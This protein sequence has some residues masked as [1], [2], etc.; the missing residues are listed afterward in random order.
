MGEQPDQHHSAAQV[1]VEAGDDVG[2]DPTA[3]WAVEHLMEVLTRRGIAVVRQP[4][5]RGVP[6]EPLR[7]SLALGGSGAP[8]APESFTVSRPADR[9]RTIA[10]TGA[11]GRGL[12]YAVLDLADTA[13]LAAD[14]LDA[15]TRTTP[16]SGVP[17][18]P[19]RS[20][21]RIF[22]SDVEDTPWFH[23]RSFWT[24]YLTE[25]ATHR[26]NRLQLAFGM[27]YN[28]SY[29]LNV[30]DNY[31]CFAY[32]FLVD[33]PGYDVRA[34]GVSDEERARNLATLQWVSAEAK[35]RGLH[36]QLGL[37]NHAYEMPE[38]PN[39]RYPITGVTPENHAE[40]ASAG[41]EA[42]LRACP[43]IDGLTLRV[44][45]EGGV[46]EPGHDF[47]RTVMGAVSRVG[48]PL[49]IDMHAKGVDA[50]L[51][52]VARGSG[53]SVVVSAKYWAEHL[54]LPYHQV[55][56]RS[57]EEA[58]KEPGTGLKS[59][60]RHQRR[61][62]RYGYGDFLRE[63]RDHGLLFRIWPGSQRVLLWGD[64]LLAAGFGRLSTIGGALGAELCEP[65]SFKGRKTS[66][67][68]GGRDPYADPDLR[69]PG[70]PWTKYRYTYRLWGRLLYD[71]DADPASWRRFLQHEFGAAAADVE[72]ALGAASRVLP[73]VTVAHGPSASNNYY[74]P[75]MYVPMPLAGGASSWH[76]H[77][78]TPEPGTLGAASPFDPGL[79]DRIDDHADDL[80]AG[81]R[82]GRY[83]PADV[84]ARLERLA[85]DAERALR[86]AVAASPDPA[87]PVFRRMAVD[88]TAQVGL[89]RFYAGVLRAGLAY[90]LHQRTKD[91]QYLSDAVGA[92]RAARDAFAA[93]V[94]VT[95]G[96][97]RPDLTFGDRVAEHGHWADRLPAIED[98]LAALEKELE[99]ALAAAPPDAAPVPVPAIHATDRPGLRHTPP[100]AFRPGTE[101]VLTAA[102]DG[103]FDGVVELHYRHLNQG[104]HHRTV[105]LTG[106]GGQLRAA[107][108]ADY[109]DSPYPLMYF[110]VLRHSG[111]DAWIVP[112]LDE[113]LANQPYH[114][115]RQE[116]R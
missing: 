81:R 22:V 45:Y 84:A 52:D 105:E 111:G 35:R 71:P 42:L 75:E 65:L 112:G 36:F 48:R 53:A 66:G 73:L 79:F 63:D 24:E 27:Q 33:V 19:V 90:A 114:V 41:L 64:P 57:L 78:D 82:S 43:A 21:S 85:D 26:I 68:A 83:G 1:V 109:T 104:E 29:D 15:L 44:H 80:L 58:T 116:R 17:A 61:F 102:L 99:A 11:D 67:E 13:A 69:L 98:D 77:F 86:Q 6:G 100:T 91:V 38:S 9:P 54:G 89:G 87:P 4:V 46:P 59:I 39:P 28:Y 76:Y 62:T 5:G 96:V 110:F 95:T 72:A 93:V 92:Y 50:G 23:D 30:R 106:E 70:D 3:R 2:T 113:T 32:P 25:L 34:G 101:V 14:P 31:L 18:T 55:S 97:Y 51:V 94:D 107:V 108:P 40:Y 60:T 88:V 10:V 20:V 115:V 103:P 47:W 8:G 7:I 12:A 16:A 49:E 74:W 37:W 56:V